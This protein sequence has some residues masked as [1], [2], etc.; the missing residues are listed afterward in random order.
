MNYPKKVNRLRRKKQREATKRDGMVKVNGIIM[1]DG[2]ATTYH[3][4]TVLV[5]KLGS[6]KV[7]NT[8]TVERL[9]EPGSLPEMCP[10]CEGRA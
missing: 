6:V 7:I 3:P 9:A 1:L 8:I 5:F 2:K 10:R 4:K